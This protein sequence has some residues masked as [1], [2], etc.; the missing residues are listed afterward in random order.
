MGMKNLKGGEVCSTTGGWIMSEGV[1]TYTEY[2]EER[3]NAANRS[4]FVSFLCNSSQDMETS[5]SAN[6]VTLIWSS[7]HTFWIN[8]SVWSVWEYE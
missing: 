5:D 3:Q 8:F 4:L 7:S 2:E 6:Y 1:Y